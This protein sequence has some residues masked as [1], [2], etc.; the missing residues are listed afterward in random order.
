MIIHSATR[1]AFCYTFNTLS[2]EV[3]QV[4]PTNRF[5]SPLGEYPAACCDW[6]VDWAITGCNKA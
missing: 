6:V 4:K 1:S 5:Y 2:K 3:C